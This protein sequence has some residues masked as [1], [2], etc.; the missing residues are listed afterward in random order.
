MRN[1]PRELLLTVHR[2][3]VRGWES[4]N[5]DLLRELYSSEAVIFNTIPP[6]RFSDF[7]T[8]ENTVQQYITQLQDLAIFTSNIQIEISEDVAWIMSQYMLVYR[9]NGQ[10]QRQHGRWTEIYQQE[11]GDWKLRHF[12]SSPDP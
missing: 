7:K 4:K 3:H 5:F 8:F 6:P 9:D 2:K 12:H 11:N 10:T 1:N